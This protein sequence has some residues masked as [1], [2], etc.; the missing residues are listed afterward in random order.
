MKKPYKDFVESLS[1]LQQQAKTERVSFH[2]LLTALNGRGRL[3]LLIVLSLGFGQIPG[4][5]LLF[6]IFVSY[7]GLRIALKKSFVWIPKWLR[8]KKIPSYFLIKVIQQILGF[9]KFMKKWSHPRYEWATQGTVARVITGLM[10][11]FVGLSFTI[12]PPLPLTGIVAFIAMFFISIGLLNDDGIYIGI[13][14]F[15]TIFYFLL[16]LVLLKYCSL[17]QL[18]DYM[19]CLIAYFNS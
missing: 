11:F 1:D 7:L 18:I 6:G 10:I 13:G 8:S 5:A 3:L 15:F 16:A 19:K 2:D 17:S 12:C 14:Y 4:I 9:L